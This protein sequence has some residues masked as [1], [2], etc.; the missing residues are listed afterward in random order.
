[1]TLAPTAFWTPVLRSR[2][3]FIKIEDDDYDYDY[4]YE[5]ED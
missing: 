2:E 4:D 3:R 5:C 1:M